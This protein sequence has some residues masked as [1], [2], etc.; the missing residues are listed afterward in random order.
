MSFSWF[1]DS[2]EASN[3]LESTPYC[4]VYV[5]PFYNSLGEKL[6]YISTDI[7]LDTSLKALESINLG[8]GSTFAL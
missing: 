6:G 5:K 4:A 8:E 3:N 7:K 1:I 2:Y